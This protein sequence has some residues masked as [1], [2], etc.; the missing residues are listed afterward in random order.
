[1]KRIVVIILSV[2]MA[3][4]VFALA[5]CSQEAFEKGEGANVNSL[6]TRNLKRGTYMSK[7][8]YKDFY[9]EDIEYAHRNIPALEYESDF[10]DC[11]RYTGLYSMIIRLN[12]LNGKKNTKE[13]KN[14]AEGFEY[15]KGR[16]S[17]YRP[18]INEDKTRS[19]TVFAVNRASAKG[20]AMVGG[21]E[22]VFDDQIWIAR[23]YL[24]AYNLFGDIEY[25]NTAV[26]LSE[27]IYLSGWMPVIGG[28][29]WGQSY[30]TRHSCSNAPFV[31]VLIELADAVES[32]KASSAETYRNWAKNVYEWTY[33]T[34][35]DPADNLYWDLVGTIYDTD[36]TP[37]RN[38]SIDKAKYTYNSGAMISAGVAMYKLTGEQRYLD[39]AKATAKSCY[40]NFG[41]HGFVDGCTMYPSD[42][43]TWFNLVMYIG[44]YDL[45]LADNT[46]TLYLDDLQRTI[47]YAYENFGRDGYIPVSWLVGWEAGWEKSDCKNL[48]DHSSHAETYLLLAQYQ[49][50]KQELLAA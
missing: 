44:Y 19:Y 11:W 40:E 15:Y 39:E 48:L 33:S 23:E 4:S 14:V 8:M 37:L 47:D 2:L 5:G 43:T 16:R 36:G 24:N 6:Y 49:K 13:F 9:N 3:L 17:G 1:M 12:E 26:E 32:T 42:T 20:K 50:S 25:L 18:G 21:K 35:R 38:D 29:T 27:Y 28:I 10:S 45:F 30:D 41:V 22:S 31:K 34:L 46:Q 7:T